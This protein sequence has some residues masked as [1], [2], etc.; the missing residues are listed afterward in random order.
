MPAFAAPDKLC[1]D[2]DIENTKYK[3]S[4]QFNGTCYRLIKDDEPPYSAYTAER[5]CQESFGHLASI[6]SKD[7]K[8]HIVDTFT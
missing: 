6:H 2:I 4:E 8:A 1:A 3:D 5:K 7:E